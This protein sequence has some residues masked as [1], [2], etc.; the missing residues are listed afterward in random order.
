MEVALVVVE[1]TLV[2]A[3]EVYVSVVVGMAGMDLIASQYL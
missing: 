2:A 1:D 3:K